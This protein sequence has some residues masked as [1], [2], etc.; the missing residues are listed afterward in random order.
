MTSDASDPILKGTDGKIYMACVLSKDDFAAKPLFAAMLRFNINGPRYSLL[1][2]AC[3]LNKLF[4]WSKII[5]HPEEKFPLSKVADRYEYWVTERTKRYERKFKTSISPIPKLSA[6]VVDGLTFIERAMSIMVLSLDTAAKCGLS[7]SLLN[8][9]QPKSSDSASDRGETQ[10][11]HGVPQVQS[12]PHPVAKDCHDVHPSKSSQDKDQL[13]DGAGRSETRYVSGQGDHI[14]AL[15]M[16]RGGLGD[17]ASILQ[18]NPTPS[19][20]EMTAGADNLHLSRTTEEETPMYEEDDPSCRNLE[21]DADGPGHIQL[22][23]DREIEDALASITPTGG[24]EDNPDSAKAAALIKKLQ[25]SLKE[26]DFMISTLNQL[27]A[28][29]ED[30]LKH[31]QEH[32]AKSIAEGLEPALKKAIASLKTDWRKEVREDIEKMKA[33]LVEEVRRL[34]VQ[35]HASTKSTLAAV[36]GSVS[37]MSKDVLSLTKTAQ[38]TYGAAVLTNQKLD[39]C[40]IVVQSDPDLQVDIPETLVSIN[41]KLEEHDQEGGEGAPQYKDDVGRPETQYVPQV[42]PI[43]QPMSKPLSESFVEPSLHSGNYLNHPPPPLAPGHFHSPA[44]RVNTQPPLASPAPPQAPFKNSWGP[45]GR[46]SRSRRTTPT[47]E[48]RK[49]FSAAPPHSK[50]KHTG[51][52]ANNSKGDSFS[53][54]PFLYQEMLQ[55]KGINQQGAWKDDQKMTQEEINQKLAVL[56]GQQTR[57]KRSRKN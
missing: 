5:L 49:S 14:L 3:E 35:E 40:G 33:S 36:N 23:L 37:S 55:A 6:C 21:N 1:E 13:E 45:R 16:E 29:Q 57:A 32:S 54:K 28:A 39:A 42:Q 2:E 48:N 24:E 25:D 53:T 12:S 22:D 9:S 31:Q 8:A 17:A 34:F 20:S 4:F 38:S 41:S 52:H 46:G 15:A 43:S 30:R 11:Q 27:T 51:L 47:P 10:G 44:P 7:V 18:A 56:G 50:V 19:H 26:R